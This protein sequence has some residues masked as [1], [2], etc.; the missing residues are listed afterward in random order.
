V[1][2]SD[3]SADGRHDFDFIFGTWSISNRRL[4]DQ[5]D[6]RCT[7][8]VEFVTESEARRSSTASGMW[9][10]SPPAPMCPADAGR[11]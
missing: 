7:E 6:P 4:A 10:S 5:T 8:W 11:V 1:H 9:T 3:P 2:E